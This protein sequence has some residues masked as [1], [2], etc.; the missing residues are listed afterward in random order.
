VDL[1]GLLD[2]KE[3]QKKANQ[4]TFVVDFIIDAVPV[5]KGRP[6]FS[7]R[8]GFVKA[9]TPAKTSD[10]ET[11]VRTEAVKA[12]GSSSPLDGA[13]ALSMRFYL[14]IPASW[15]KKRTEA[16]KSGQERHVKKPDVDNFAKAVMDACNGVLFVDDSQVV[17]MHVAKYYSDWPRVAVTMLEV[18]ND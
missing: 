11:V 6:R 12:M 1:R 10:W 8:G 3:Q 5:A 17:D 15:S 7:S 18:I 9:Y 4:M 14:P 2:C 13:V 16:A